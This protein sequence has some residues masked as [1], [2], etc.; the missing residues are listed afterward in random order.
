M[1]EDERD[2]VFD[3]IPGDMWI[4]PNEQEGE[5][6]S[7]ADWEWW[8]DLLGH[9]QAHPGCCKTCGCAASC[10]LSTFYDAMITSV[11]REL[12][13]RGLLRPASEAKEPES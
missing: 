4:W 12:D 11:L 6:F 10:T 8:R 3:L 7:H 5:H 13:V 2:E 1:T 9:P